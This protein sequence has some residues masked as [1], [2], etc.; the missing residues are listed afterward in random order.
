MSIREFRTPIKLILFLSSYV[1][2][3][4]IIGME[5]WDFGPMLVSV[6]TVPHISYTVGLSYVSASIFLGCI[7]V[8]KYLYLIIHTHSERA[9][10]QYPIDTYKK[11]NEMLATYLLVYVFVF[12]GLD[13]TQPMDVGIFIIFFFMLA[14]TQ[15]KSGHIYVNPM[16]GIRGY[17]VYEITSDEKIVLVIS[18]GTISEKVTETEAQLESSPRKKIEVVSMDNTTVLAPKHDAES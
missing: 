5:L 7:V 17:Q 6:Y 1:P 15:I 14:V 12:V 18:K 8:T 13:F 9:T 4:I 10:T 2:L 3:F 16:L 11:R